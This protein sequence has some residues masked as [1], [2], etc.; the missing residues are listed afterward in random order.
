MKILIVSQYFWPEEF[1]VNDLA[2]DLIERGNDVTVLT[3][4]PNYPK[5]KFYNG[6]GFKY[7]K[8]SYKGVK[9]YRVPIIPRGN[10][11]ITLILNYLSFVLTGSFFAAFHKTKYDKIFAV[12]FSP[13]T[14]VF[15]AI[16]YKML[17]KIPLYLW[18]QDLWPESV[19]AASTIKIEFIDKLLLVMVKYIYR[20]CD[21]ILVSNFGFIESIES[22]DIEGAKI[23]FMPNWA[24]DLFEDVNYIFADKYKS[25]LPDGF[26]VMFAGNVGEAQ[27][28]ESII[29]AASLTNHIESIKWII[30]GDGRKRKWLQ[31]EII[32]RKLSSTVL[33]L[34]RFPVEEMPSFFTHANI[35]LV[36]LK[37]EYIF[38]LTV[39]AKV[40]SYTAF[41]QPIVTMLSGAG[42]IVVN[43][44]NC[45][46]TAESS[47]YKTLAENVIKASLM[48]KSDLEQLGNNGQ[49]YY[50]EHFA[51]KKVID[52]FINIL[53]E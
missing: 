43:E 27:D 53:S 49:K 51:K 4:N 10:N 14:A 41:G 12:N 25:I 29:E 47:D 33:S 35:M 13:I 45:G 18:V 32:K 36:T 31:N 23:S 42:N 50:K 1:R 24:E 52:N 39:P 26:I 46:Y 44:A 9:I 22:K 6:Y 30:I 40:Q 3:G 2:F 8:E 11:N 38:S 37:N 7:L 34:G 16:I 19:R 17:H 5:G 48:Q 20:K 28:F 15:P 21:K